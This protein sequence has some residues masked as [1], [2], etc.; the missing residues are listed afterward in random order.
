MCFKLTIKLFQ[1]CVVYS[2]V[3][4]RV[5]QKLNNEVGLNEKSDSVSDLFIIISFV[6]LN[7]L[8]SVSTIWLEQT[9]ISYTNTKCFHNGPVLL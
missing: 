7:G 9:I 1:F 2:V 3:V 8:T 4:Q 5:T 6:G